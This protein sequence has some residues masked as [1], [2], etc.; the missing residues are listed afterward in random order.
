M[1]K[2][3]F[4]FCVLQICGVALADMSGAPG[5]GTPGSEI[6]EMPAM[7]DLEALLQGMQGGTQDD[8]SWSFVYDELVLKPYY[9]S[10][11]VAIPAGL[12][13]LRGAYEYGTA[14]SKLLAQDTVSG[15]LSSFLSTNGKAFSWGTVVGFMITMGL[16][17]GSYEISKRSVRWLVS[18]YYLDAFFKAWDKN[19]KRIPKELVA[20]FEREYALYKKEG[21]AYRWNTSRIVDIVSAAYTVQK[22]KIDLLAK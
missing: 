5:S 8:G 20:F 12:C 22:H 4:I 15:W 18:W 1:K 19:C 13:A 9:L 21:S 17:A 6:P 3:V 2:Y 16:I 7:P 10:H 14:P 11:F